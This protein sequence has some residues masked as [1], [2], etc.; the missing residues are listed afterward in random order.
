VSAQ[1]RPSRGSVH[2]WHLS[3]PSP[4][5]HRVALGQEQTFEGKIFGFRDLSGSRIK[6]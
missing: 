5:P 1:Y 4:A 3:Y 6:P 2:R